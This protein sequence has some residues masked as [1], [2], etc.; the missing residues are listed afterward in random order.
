MASICEVCGELKHGWARYKGE[1]MCIECA[2]TLKKEDILNRASESDSAPFFKD[3]SNKDRTTAFFEAFG[4]YQ[5][6]PNARDFK[7][8]MHLWYWSIHADHGL[9]TTISYTFKWAKFNVNEERQRWI[10]V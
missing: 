6:E 9:S 10:G 7:T 4:R 5:K 8:I 1:E 3:W 2:D